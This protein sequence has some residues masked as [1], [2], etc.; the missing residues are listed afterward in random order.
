VFLRGQRNPGILGSRKRSDL[1]IFDSSYNHQMRWRKESYRA[2]QRFRNTDIIK[3][4]QQ[5][6]QSPALEQPTDPDSS[7]YRV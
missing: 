6:H 5:D 2:K 7:G 1:G 4:R 3:I